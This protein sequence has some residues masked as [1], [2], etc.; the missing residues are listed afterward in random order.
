MLLV[1][2]RVSQPGRHVRPRAVYGFQPQSRVPRISCSYPNQA[3]RGL[4]GAKTVRTKGTRVAVSKYRALF[5]YVRGYYT[6]SLIVNWQPRSPRGGALML[7]KSAL[8]A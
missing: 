5:S 1:S 2:T 4:T 7:L 8:G 3:G 6:V